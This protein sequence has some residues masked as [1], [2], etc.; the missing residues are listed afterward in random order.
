M[1]CC[2]YGGCLG[3]RTC[4]SVAEW[5]GLLRNDQI[6]TGP[7]TRK[8]KRVPNDEGSL[9][10]VTTQS[11]R[12]TDLA[13]MDVDVNAATVMTMQALERFEAALEVFATERF[14][15]SR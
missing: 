13:G 3:Y 11:R 8:V 9:G 7:Y 10:Y 6:T 15:F 14:C 12:P 5:Q 1:L 4:D 2:A